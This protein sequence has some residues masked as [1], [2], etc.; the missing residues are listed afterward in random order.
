[1][2]ASRH[3][4]N[5]TDISIEALFENLLD[6]WNERDASGYAA[7]FADDGSLVGFD[8]SPI[9]TA[10]AI[11]K[12]L[13][14]IFTDHQP[15]TYVAKV[16]EVRSL[17]PDTVLL[18]AVA[19]MIPPGA[20]DIKPEVNAIQALVAVRRDGA[21]RVAHFQNTPAAFHGRPDAVQALTA[22]LQSLTR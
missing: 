12:H 9:E 11:A 17:G 22:E 15:A 16:R 21:W 13:E 1:M 19:G 18:R 3:A 8:G 2:T 5:A 7:L 20:D 4:D 14:S 10:A 6:R